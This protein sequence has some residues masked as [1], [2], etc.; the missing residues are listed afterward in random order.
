MNQNNAIASKGVKKNKSDG[1]R[2]VTEGAFLI[3]T[4][5]AFNAWRARLPLAK[6]IKDNGY[7]VTVAAA[8]DA[9][10]DARIQSEG[11][12]FLH[13]PF[14]R[15]GVNLASDLMSIFVLASFLIGNHVKVCHVF[16]PK[17]I[18]LMGLLIR[19]FPRTKLFVTVTGLGDLDRGSVKTGAIRLAYKAAMSRATVVCLEN[20]HDYDFVVRSGLVN[21]AKCVVAIA[22]GVDTT[23]FPLRGKRQSDF[24]VRFLFAS[25]LLESKGL[26]E[27]LAA[28]ERLKSNYGDRV[29]VIVAGELETAHVAAVSTKQIE[30]LHAAG[31]INYVGALSSEEV[32]VA[33][34]KADVAI[35]PSY[36]EGFS[37][38]LMEGSAAGCALI[39]TDIPGCR[40][41]V[42]DGQT[43]L[44]VAAKSESALLCAMRYYVENTD[45]IYKHGMAAQRNAREHFDITLTTERNFGFYSSVL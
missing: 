16:N 6:M 37:K 44:T 32:C 29:E 19:F 30:A 23:L 38:F 42:L 8:R 18:L 12:N 40:E 21:A 4:G 35:L 2:E 11:V 22:S 27:L 24:P 41:I 3:V 10:Y 26:R 9:N 45:S 43:G 33:L 14:Y 7:P 36:R 20:Q 34:L 31:V 39:S 15:F 1:E 13:V 5:R 17:P 25:R 28:S